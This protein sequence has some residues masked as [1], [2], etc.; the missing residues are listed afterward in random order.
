[1][2]GLACLIAAGDVRRRSDLVGLLIL[3]HVISVVAMPVLLALPGLVT[4]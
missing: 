4:I 1:V 3:A 2:L